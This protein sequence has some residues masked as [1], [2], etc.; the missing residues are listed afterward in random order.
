MRSRYLAL[1]VIGGAAAAAYTVLARPWQL[2]WGATDQES[3]SH[4]PAMN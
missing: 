1:G 4:S 2:T 3:R